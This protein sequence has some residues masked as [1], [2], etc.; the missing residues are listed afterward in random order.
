MRLFRNH[1]SIRFR[2]VIHENIW[3]GIDAYRAARGGRIGRS[4][5]IF[6]H[7]GDEGDQTAKHRRNLPLLKKRLRA[8]PIGV[9]S[10]CHLASIYAALGQDRLDVDVVE[11]PADIIETLLATGKHIVQPHCVLEYGGS[12]FDQNAWREHGRV[13]L[14]A[15]RDE[16]EL[17]RLDAVG[18]TMLL[19][20]ADIHR[21]GLVFPPFPYGRANPLA[22]P[23]RG[24]LETEGL[25]L[26][27]HD[28]GHQCW[29]MPNLEIKH[30]RA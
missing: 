20:R 10:W 11:Y 27:A 22:R 14:D 23:G 16:G 5:L 30:V 1:P 21:D 9:Y 25:G 13:H 28:M 24:E 26:L 7:E 4:G 2:G 15:L 6:D 18:A 17:A 3:P 8:D 12:T 19:V 29:G